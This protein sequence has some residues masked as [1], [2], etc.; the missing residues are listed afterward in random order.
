[1]VQLSP[2]TRLEGWDGCGGYHYSD[3]FIY[4]FTH[5]HLSGTG[6]SDY[7]DILLMPMTGKPSPD[8]KIY[9]SSF[10]HAN[11][12]ASPGYYSVLLNDDNILAEL[13]ATTRAGMHR[14]TFPV[15]DQANIILDLKHRDEVIESSLK[16]EDSVTVSGMRRSKAWAQNQY[17]FFVIK[18]SKPFLKYGIYVNDTLQNNKKASFQ[19]Q[20]T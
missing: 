4:G 10:S 12:K 6:I 9:G 7:G 5:T 1:M 13:T 8:N 3:N 14:Y 16:V 18:F 19:N 17:V 2:D 15:S 20:K 11:E